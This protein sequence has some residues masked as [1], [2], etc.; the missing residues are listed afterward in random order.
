MAFW[1]NSTYEPLKSYQFRLNVGGDDWYWAKQVTLPSF[2]INQSEYTMVNQ[3][4]KYPGMLV[5]GDVSI[6]VAE[7]GIAARQVMAIL[8]ASGYACPGSCGQGCR[9]DRS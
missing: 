6:T 3:K 9:W 2:E 8:Q 1:S 5:W 7:T 4:F